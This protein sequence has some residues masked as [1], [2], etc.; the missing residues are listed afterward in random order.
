MK[1]LMANCR[2]G[3]VSKDLPVVKVNPL[4]VIVEVPV[5]W[6]RPFSRVRHVKRHK[7]KNSVNLT[8]RGWGSLSL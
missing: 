5:E 3:N 8:Y 1:A 4:T 2:F 6:R 7:V